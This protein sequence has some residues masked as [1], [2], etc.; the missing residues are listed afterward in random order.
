MVDTE[1]LESFRGLYRDLLA[2]AES[3]L[4]NVERLWAELEVRIED[5][6]NLLDKPPKS[7][8]SRQLISS[9]QIQIDDLEYTINDDFKQ[10]T[11]QLADALDL[12]ELEAARLCISAGSDAEE[13]DRTILDSSIIT[14][15]ERRQFLL[16][17]LRLILKQS[18]DPDTNGPPRKFSKELVTLILETKD[19]PGHNGLPYFQK[20]AASMVDIERWLAAL[21]ERVHTALVLNQAQPPQLKE[22]MTFQRLSLIRQHESLGAIISYLTKGN[23][24]SVEDFE[25]LLSTIKRLDKYDIILVHYLPALTTSI[26][27]FGSLEGATS[28]REARTLHRKIIASKETNPWNLRYVQGAMIAWWIAEYSG[29]YLDNPVGSPLQGVDLEMES[30]ER[31]KLF[32]E[33]LSD[34]AFQFMLSLGAH[35]KPDEWRDPARLGL[36]QFLLRDSPMMQLDSVACSDHFYQLLMEQLEAFSD[37]FIANM[38]DT[39]RKLKL[40]EDE[41]RKHAQAV[42][43]RGIQ[44]GFVE[45]QLHLERFLVI[46]S[47]AFERRPDAAEAFWADPDG[48][49][50]GFVQWAS[51]RQSTPRVSAFCEMLQSISGETECANS[52]HKF[53]LEDGSNTP[54]KFRRS[55]SLSWAQIFD[56]LQF[57]ASKIR[58]RPA[59]PQPTIYQVGK[60]RADEIDEP[61]S[62][63]MLECYLRLTSHICRHSSVARAWVLEHP[64]INL[65]DTL[66]QLCSSTIP[67]RLRACAL[68]SI[69]AL[70]TEKSSQVGEAIWSSLDHWVSG[71][72]PSTL[73]SRLNTTATASALTEEI[74]FESIAFGFEE[75]NAFIGLLR[76]L[77]APCAEGDDLNDSLPFLESIGSAYRMPGIEPYV[78]F[79][80]GRIFPQQ[81]ADIQDK[82]QLRILRCTCLHFIVTCLSTFNE[83]L[84][85]FA[86]SSNVAV[87]AAIGTSSLAAYVRLHPFA[88][89]MEWLFNEGVI[90]ALFSVAHQ[91]IGEVSDSSPDSPLVLGLLRSIEV[92][93]LVLHLQST[94]FAI[95]RPLIKMQS[96]SRRAPVSN[97][98]LAS[99]ED[100]IVNNLQ[101]VVDLGLYCGTGH[102]ELTV[103]SLQLLEKLSSSRKLVTS[104]TSA[105]GQ[106]LNKNKIIGVLEMRGDAIRIGASL[107]SEMQVDSRELDQGPNSSGFIIKTSILDFLNSCLAA[108]PGQATIAHL[109]LGFSC[110]GNSL[111]ILADSRFAKGLSL[112]HAILRVLLVY[113]DEELGD[114]LG[115]LTHIKQCAMQVLKQLWSSQLSSVYTMTELREIDFLSAQMLRQKMIDSSTCWNQRPFNDPLFIST[116]SAVCFGDYLHQR[117]SLFE[118]AATELRLV[119]HAPTLVAEVVLKLSGSIQTGEGGRTPTIFDLLDFLELEIGDDVSQPALKHFVGIDLTACLREEIDGLAAYDLASVRELLALRR[120][121]LRRSGAF[122]NPPQEEEAQLELQD[123]LLHLHAINQRRI[124]KTARLHTLK[125]WVQL[126]I[127]ILDNADFEG[128][129][130]TFILQVLQ[131]VLPRLDKYSR[132]NETEAAELA[133]LTKSLLFNLDFQSPSFENGRAGDVANDRLFQLFSI[134]LRG[135]HSPASTAFLRESFYIICYKYLTGM[136]D[137][138]DSN[139]VLRRHSIQ[140]VKAAGGRL[141]DIICDD[142]YAGSET[143]R[144]SALLLLNAL[145]SLAKQGESQHII[146]CLGRA[147]FI[148]ILVDSIKNMSSELQDANVQ[149]VRLLLSY[150]EAKLLLLLRIAQT[151]LGATQV[152]NAGLFQSVRESKLVSVDPDLGI[153]IDYPESLKKYYELLLAVIRVISSVVLSMGQQNERTMNSARSFLTENRHSI[154]SL[155][156][157][158]AGIGGVQTERS[159]NL[160]ELVDNFVLLVTV[161]GF[162]DFEERTGLPSPSALGMFT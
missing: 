103:V 128:S 137:R 132:E 80:L 79:A 125:S 130:A 18:V 73:P 55:S 17:C 106:R 76:A 23:H 155:F 114:F 149:D 126:V 16:E 131:V 156:K 31:S 66:F 115:W 8:S 96:S 20:C 101:L 90:G 63:M 30:D 39:L 144:L 111:E 87:D 135:I 27:Q 52:A 123:I 22:I 152:L 146:E 48:N 138:L 88:R 162:L 64:S 46:I 10:A 38:P 2:S 120:T 110:N 60:P 119:S 86:N 56:E 4:P 40:E 53:L 102:Q 43:Q 98:A 122:S 11:L 153:E 54:G 157:R 82:A 92:M 151:R 97:S 70:L 93:N 124:L 78:D 116:D 136:T 71:Q 112:F 91:D 45:H 35:V 75:P 140:T 72:Y 95:V 42:L 28:L 89:V 77:V 67:R 85:V 41:Q 29:L 158:H 14:F 13:L 148:G 134:C 32:V 47:Y 59:A 1:G 139:A 68:A 3:R 108:L 84:V 118:Y 34:G 141:I 94:Y 44:G 160:G 61:E 19:R 121:E 81:T 109:L 104:S 154:L 62:A 49:L 145:L 127:L 74:M 113:P 83:D 7:D 5:F 57:Y 105:F 107:A 100:A 21:S 143:C 25:A 26:A 6:K 65:V 50:Y 69:Q 129:K 36:T 99:F 142:A 33:A 161:T 117:A 15:H 37:A 159:G 133:T 24:T 147:N 51:M 9:G 12:D 58:D 150:Y